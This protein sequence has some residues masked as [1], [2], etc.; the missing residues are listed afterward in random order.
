[1]RSI[2]RVSLIGH[3]THDPK[4]TRTKDGIALAT[5]SLATN[6]RYRN[7]A[8]E[9]VEMPDFHR[10]VAW[11]KLAELCERFLHKGAAL[12]VEGRL[13]T[14]VWKDSEGKRKEQQEV[15]VTSLNILRLKGDKIQAEELLGKE[16][17]LVSLAAKEAGKLAKSIKGAKKVG[18]LLEDVKVKVVASA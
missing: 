13:S 1:M 6:R 15:V 10:L 5:F 9:W 2:N 18:K 7:D 11:R 12:Y 16:E 3:L 4:V 17:K 14:S 8:G